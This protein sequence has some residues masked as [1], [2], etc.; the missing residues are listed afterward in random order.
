MTIREQIKAVN[1]ALSGTL[2]VYRIWAKKNGLNY[3]EL[4]VL[5][6]LDDYGSCTPKQISDY[7]A[8][9]K[10]TTN[11][12][13]RD[14]ENKGYICVEPGAQDKRERL[15][16]F[17]ESGKQFAASILNPLYKMEELAMRNLGPESCGQLVT[18]NTLYCNL[19]KNE[20]DQARGL[21]S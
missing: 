6:T 9:P 17:T 18:C 10:Q 13:L 14:F 5:Y 8:L 1:L 4:I 15:V 20:I 12:I 11:G 19:L 7:W 21:N 2:E 3:N 16:A